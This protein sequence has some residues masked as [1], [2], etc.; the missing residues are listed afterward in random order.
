MLN[1]YL[2]TCRWE[3]NG[4]RFPL[5]NCWG[6]VRLARHE[7]FGLP[8]LRES[9]CPAEDARFMTREALD[10]ISALRPC[11]PGPGAVAFCWSGRLCLHV[12]LVIESERRLAVLDIDKGRGACITPLADWRRKY[13]RVSFHAD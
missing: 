5:L 10:V 12:G 11:E 1:R 8:M 2:M 3:Q 9:D 7:L 4:M 13:Q 6:L